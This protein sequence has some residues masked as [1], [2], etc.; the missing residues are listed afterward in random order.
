MEV[1][2]HPRL[3]ILEHIVDVSQYKAPGDC[4]EIW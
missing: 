2:V 4:R 3:D 1:I